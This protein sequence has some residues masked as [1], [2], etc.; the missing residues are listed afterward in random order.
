MNPQS[1]MV[2]FAVTLFLGLAPAR[3]AGDLP[4]WKAVDEPWGAWNEVQFTDSQKAY[5]SLWCHYTECGSKSKA[6][7][8]ALYLF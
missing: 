2:I 4:T 6:K 8:A 1:R 5:H 3:A 7:T